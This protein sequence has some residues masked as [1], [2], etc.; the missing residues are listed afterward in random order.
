MRRYCAAWYGP[1]C[2]RALCAS[3]LLW[4][5]LWCPRTSSHFCVRPVLSEQCLSAAPGPDGGMLAT[6]DA[7]GNQWCIGGYG[8]EGQLGG[9]PCTSGLPVYSL[10]GSEGVVNT[11]LSGSRECVC[12]CGSAHA[13]CTT[14][15][16][17]FVWCAAAAAVSS[18]SAW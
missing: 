5:A 18:W 10:Q 14:L 17:V 12:G 6:K 2:T 13:L 11:T 16:G 8:S 9:F 4:I 1:C 3:L 15:C 7:A